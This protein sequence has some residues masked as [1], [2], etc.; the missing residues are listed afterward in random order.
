MIKPYIHRFGMKLVHAATGEWLRVGH[1]ATDVHKQTH[2]IQGGECPVR[3]PPNGAVFTSRGSFRPHTLH[4]RWEA[5]S[6]VEQEVASAL[7]GVEYN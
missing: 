6:S 3:H 7:P 1:I 5:M 2:V 4:C